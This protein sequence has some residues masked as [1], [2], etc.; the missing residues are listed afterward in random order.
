MIYIFSQK[1][2][3]ST[4]DI[5]D[6]LQFY[7]QP[8]LRIDRDD[9]DAHQAVFDRLS[10]TG[11]RIG[12]SGVETF[13]DEKAVFWFRRPGGDVANRLGSKIFPEEAIEFPNFKDDSKLLGS[14]HQN[15]AM[16]LRTYFHV[17]LNNETNSLGSY[18][19]TSL[20]KLEVLD[21]AQQ[22]GLNIPA[23]VVTNDMGLLTEFYEEHDQDI[24]CKTLYEIIYP[25]GV[26]EEGFT[27][28]CHTA[29]VE[30]LEDLPTQFFPTLF[31]KNIRKK[32][33]LRVFY[34]KGRCFTAAMFSQA[35]AQTEIDFRNS[36]RE[37]PTRIVPYQ[38]DQQ[39]EAQIVA[40][41]KAVGLNTGSID[42]I[43]GTD[44]NYYFLEINPVGQFGFISAPCNYG[45]DEVIANELID[46]HA[47]V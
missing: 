43:R 38:L 40:L 35:N 3:I 42:L 2:D 14:L 27:I 15:Y 34:I 6:W 10:A 46:M 7:K 21:A 11:L 44:G 28:R 32:Y 24:I 4:N 18:F 23:T 37:N 39:L 47:A 31:Q 20:N 26:Q 33:E 41:M 9:Q 36:D 12:K 17:L 22:L 45:L 8:F 30:S 25:A 16:Y 1:E 29:V 19:R 5:I 13:Q